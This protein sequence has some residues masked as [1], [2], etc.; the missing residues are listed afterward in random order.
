LGLSCAIDEAAAS[1]HLWNQFE[2]MESAPMLLGF[3]S[4]F[5]DHRQGRDPSTARIESLVFILKEGFELEMARR[6]NATTTPQPFAVGGIS[7]VP[8]RKREPKL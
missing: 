1:S 3:Q 2:S 4:E 5:K 7:V 6:T 8:G